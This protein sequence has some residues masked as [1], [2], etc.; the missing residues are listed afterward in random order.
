M[1]QAVARCHTLIELFSHSWKTTRDLR[2]KQQQLGLPQHKLTT[3]VSTRWGSTYG[4]VSRVLEQQQAICA[5]VAEDHKNRHK[6]PT[7]SEFLTLEAIVKV[8][9]PLSYF[10]DALSGEKCVTASA[11]QLLL[12]HIYKKI[13]CESP[14]DCTISKEM[15]S[16]MMV[17]LNTHYPIL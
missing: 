6:M 2:L 4:M 15:K 5:V 14:D 11:V 1:Q 9:K 17:D 7:N 16:L 13:L 8:F 10:T 12:D 3:D